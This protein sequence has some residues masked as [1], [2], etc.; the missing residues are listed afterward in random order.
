MNS[1][2]VGTPYIEKMLVLTKGNLYVVSYVVRGG[3]I[4]IV[5]HKPAV[6]RFIGTCLTSG[7]YCCLVCFGV[8]SNS[9]AAKMIRFLCRFYRHLS[10]IKTDKWEH[11]RLL[12]M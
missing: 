2:R 3:L 4:C 8:V 12:S 1:R 7:L 11:F 5:L 9:I 10:D 6:L